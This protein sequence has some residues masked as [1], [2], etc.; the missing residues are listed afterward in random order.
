MKIIIVGC[1]NVG[2][3]IAEQLSKEDHNVTVIDI[4]EVL[5]D[6]FSSTHDVMGL[7]GNGTTSITLQEAGIKDADLHIAVTASDELNLLSCLIAKKCGGE[8]LKTI[9]RVSNP[10]YGKEIGFIKEGMGLSM[11][12]NPQRAS[13]SEVRQ[14]IRFPSALNI[15]SFSRSRVDLVSYRLKESSSLCGKKLKDLQSLTAGKVLI[16]LI[17]RDGEIIVPDGE[18]ELLPKDIISILGGSEN[19]EEFFNEVEEAT[20]HINDAMILGGGRTSIY[21]A[22]VLISMGVDV[23]I[24]E[25]KDYKCERIAEMVPKATIICGNG[26]D[27]DLLKEEGVEQVDMFIANTNYDEENIMISMY[28]NQISD[29]KII[30]KVRRTEYDTLL[31]TLNFGSVVYPK[32]ITVERICRFVRGMHHATGANI[33]SLHKLFDDRVEAIEFIIK[34][35]CP[36]LGKT[37]SE[38]DLKKGVIVGCIN[39]NG[40]TSIAT[41]DSKIEAGDT[42]IIITTIIGVDEVDDIIN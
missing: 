39:H 30:A 18:T 42:V 32:R 28:V 26:K 7:V 5:V 14:L 11:V 31:D 6:D 37:L 36:F 27:K 41:G 10:E 16:P 17:E 2:S 35:D 19:T 22:K 29:A 24:I 15:D 21:L 20:K 38:I 8:K 13:A 25:H 9:A 1:G 23:K 34:D 4:D 40:E 33:V 12:I 3:A